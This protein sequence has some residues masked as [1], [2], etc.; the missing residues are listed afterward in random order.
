[1]YKV[2]DN[3]LSDK[4][5]AKLQNILMG[6]GMPWYYNPN[7][8]TDVVDHKHLYMSHK[9]YGNNQFSDMFQFVKPLINKIEPDSLI[10]VKANLYPNQGEIYKHDYH[11]DYEFSHQA[12]VF[13]INDNDGGTIML[14]GEVVKSASNRIVF[15]DGSDMHS[16]T[17]CTDASA[18]ININVNYMKEDA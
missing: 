7:I 18:R 12:A 9:F 5:F 2:I 15:F 13:G 8:T 17:T 11:Y 16:S 14:D 10:R 3:F 6:N 1:M 4:E